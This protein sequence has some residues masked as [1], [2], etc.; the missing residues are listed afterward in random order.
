VQLLRRPAYRSA[1]LH[2]V[3]AGVEHESVCFAHE[4]ATVIDVGANHGQ[5]A[6][7][8]AGRFPGAALICLEPLAAQRAKLSSVL[9]GR[10]DVTILDVAASA[11]DGRQQFHVSRSADSS[12]LLEPSEAMTRVFPGTESITTIEIETARLDAILSHAPA[13]PCL[14][15]IDVQGAEL[16]VLRGATRLL[17]EIDEVYVECSLVELYAGQALLDD[18]VVHLAERDFRL[19]G[20]HSLVRDKRGRCLQADVLF[21]RR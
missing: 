6:V 13:R 11:S 12:S 14:L 3:A 17:N 1:L 16:D 8:A 15:K 19:R 21:S 5:F 9:A 4:F 7:F 10:H 20:I 18:V 2:G